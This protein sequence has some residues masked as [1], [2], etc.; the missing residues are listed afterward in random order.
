MKSNKATVVEYPLVNGGFALVDA[1][2]VP[3]LAG[4]TWRRVKCSNRFYARCNLSA[5]TSSRH[6]YMHRFLLGASGSRYP[7]VDHIDGDGL[8][9]SRSNIRFAT[10]SQNAQN[11]AQRKEGFRGVFKQGRGYIARSG[12]VYGGFFADPLSAAL[13]FDRIALSLYGPLAQV[14]FRA[15]NDE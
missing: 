3:L 12:K 13:A 8:N 15:A 14:N 9:N 2:D 11:T 1:D 4:R 10:P 7:W 6:V 5:G